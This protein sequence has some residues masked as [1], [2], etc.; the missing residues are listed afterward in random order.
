M[1]PQSLRSETLS[2]PA[3]T[4]GWVQNRNLRESGP[5]QAEVLDN[6]F[7]TARDAVLRGGSA[8]VARVPGGVTALMPYDAG[9]TQVLVAATATTLTVINNYLEIPSIGFGVPHDD[10]SLFD[11]GVGYDLGM[12]DAD[13]T[14]LSSGDWSH[15]QFANSSGEYLYMTNGSPY[16]FNGSTVSAQT[17][18]G[19]SGSL[20]AVWNFG[21][22][23]FFVEEN[24]LSAWYLDV[25]AI[26]GAATEFPLQ[27]VFSQGGSLLFG[28]TW[29]LDSGEG[30]DDKCVF[31][32]N[33]GEVAVYGGSDPSSNFQLEGVYQIARPTGKN[34]WFRSG[35]DLAISTEEGIVSIGTAV[36]RDRA[37]LGQDAITFPIEEPWVDAIANR[38]SEARFGLVFWRKG[39]RLFVHGIQDKGVKV[40][41]VIN[42]QTGAWCRYVGWDMQAGCVLDGRLYFG[43]ANGYIHLTNVGGTDSGDAVTATYVSRFDLADNVGGKEA[44]HGRLVARSSAD[45]NPAIFACADYIVTLPGSVNGTAGS[46]GAAW[47]TATWGNFVWGGSSPTVAVQEWQAVSALGSSLAVGAQIKS[48]GTEQ[49]DFALA[50]MDL[51]YR[52]GNLA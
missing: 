16:T 13:L 30:L 17:V 14:G 10:D 48:T 11:D 44:L 49:W 26:S 43:D 20:P 35:G 22:R 8:R 25:N 15:T 38:T 21:K 23:I 18:S 46:R 19:P 6:L 52:Q 1:R 50:G 33:L 40:Q 9:N 24:T 12:E 2:L 29:S 31:V 47:D 7:P 36:Q 37:A 34:D 3:P 27:G 45:V 5:N 32:T 41:Y 39:G 51:V 42:A 28:A 4:G